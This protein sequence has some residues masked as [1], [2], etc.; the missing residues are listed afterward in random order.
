VNDDEIPRL[1]EQIAARLRLRRP[2]RDW[3]DEC[4]EADG[5]GLKT[6]EAAAIAGV[7]A[8]TIRRRCEAA[9][10]AGKPIGVLQARAVWLISQRR[11]PQL[12]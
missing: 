8:D 6:D 11:L 12:D 4:L 2:R 1:L 9:G 10:A 5:D 7:S 3:L